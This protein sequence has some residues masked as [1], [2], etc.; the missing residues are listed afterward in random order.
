M[1]ILIVD[2]HPM[3]RKG[4]ST[5]LALQPE[6]EQVLE[7]ASIAEAINIIA[8]ENRPM[9]AFAAIHIHILQPII[10]ITICVHFS[11]QILIALGGGGIG[12][13]DER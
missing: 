11:I 1:K 12:S 4:L 3:V 10:I 9:E 2:D 13:N 5:V 7:A 6:V 8:Q